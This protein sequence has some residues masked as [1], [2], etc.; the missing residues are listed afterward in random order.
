MKKKKD[1][2]SFKM[3]PIL[4]IT[5]EDAFFFKASLKLANTEHEPPDT[6]QKLVAMYKKIYSKLWE[7]ILNKNYDTWMSSE[8]TATLVNEIN[9]TYSHGKPESSCKS[10]VTE[11]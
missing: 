9:A 5:Q 4:E 10:L 2:L 6:P 11:M 1:D 7:S 8:N 3:M